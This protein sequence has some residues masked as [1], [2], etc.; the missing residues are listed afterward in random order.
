MNNT[1]ISILT[2][3]TPFIDKIKEKGIPI[4]QNNSFMYT[5]VIPVNA[6]LK[7]CNFLEKF[8]EEIKA[9]VSMYVFCQDPETGESRDYWMI[10]VEGETFP[11]VEEVEKEKTRIKILA[12]RCWFH[13]VL[14]P[15]E[16]KQA[17]LDYITSHPKTFKVRKAKEE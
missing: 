1:L 12:L 4:T 3:S 15:E 13:G 10:Y 2:S 5:I 11:K 6:E 16:D 9:T 7:V 17:V 14:P 8:A